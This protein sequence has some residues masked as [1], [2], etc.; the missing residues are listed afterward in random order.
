[1]APG[2]YAPFASDGKAVEIISEEGPAET[3]VDASLLWPLGITNRCA[4]LGE[5]PSSTNTV[6]SGF[7]L[8]NGNAER[9]GGSF[10]GT[11]EDCILKD[12]VAAI[13]GAAYGGVLI[14]CILQGNMGRIGG[15]AYGGILVD[16]F[17]LDNVST[18]GEVTELSVLE[19]CDIEEVDSGGQ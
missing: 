11:L 4:T 19:N 5:D 15:A 1:M 17:L 10:A 12:N 2:E 13:G 7:S 6:L 9:G 14:D 18:E 3:V 16:C 8:V